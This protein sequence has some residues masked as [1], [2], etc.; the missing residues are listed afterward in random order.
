MNYTSVFDIMG[1]IMIGPSSS[2][3]AGA[4]R[5]GLFARRLFGKMP[6]E[7]EITLYGSFAK[8]YKGHA[9][10][11]ALV[12]GLLNF[13][14]DD[15]RIRQSI[16]LAKAA[17]MEV[18]FILSDEE[19]R[20]PNT[21]L[22]KLRDGVEELDIMGESIGGGKMRITGIDTFE[23]TV[24]DQNPSLFVVAEKGKDVLT[25]VREVLENGNNPISNVEVA[26]NHGEIGALLE[27]KRK[28]SA[29]TVAQL[30]QK[31]PDIIEIKS[32]G[33]ASDVS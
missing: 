13:E 26:R 8:T 14:T 27:L 1:P 18:R 17:G 4:A 3:T 22:L 33:G 31:I 24:P 16:G 7:V 12:G 32:I 2:H 5:I 15:E 19:P 28:A 10:D 29:K 25:E 6:L 20:H 9:T 30:K 11:V 21:V 23:L